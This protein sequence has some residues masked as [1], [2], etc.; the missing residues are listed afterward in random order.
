VTKIN[1]AGRE[2]PSWCIRDHQAGDSATQS[3]IGT[4]R[5]TRVAGAEARL[6]DLDKTPEVAAWLSGHS[7]LTT[8]FADTPYRAEWLANFIEVAADT[9]QADLRSLAAHVRAAAAEAWPE[10][11]PEAGS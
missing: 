7:G 9:P 1:R 4:V 6:Y 3:C 5:S 2:C 10:Q 11:E 8:A